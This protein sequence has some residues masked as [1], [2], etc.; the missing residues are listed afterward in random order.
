MPPKLLSS[1]SITVW[2]PDFAPRV[3]RERNVDSSGPIDPMLPRDHTRKVGITLLLLVSWRRC[4]ELAQAIHPRN[5]HSMSLPQ[6]IVVIGQFPGN[7]KTERAHNLWDAR[8]GHHRYSLGGRWSWDHESVL[9]SLEVE[10]Q[11][12]CIYLYEHRRVLGVSYYISKLLQPNVLIHSYNNTL[13]TITYLHAAT[14][15]QLLLTQEYTNL[16]RRHSC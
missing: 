15:Q 14:P 12:E 2:A 6:G 10:R 4:L 5:R 3:S 16:L 9:T 1:S 13:F 7:M 8:G 11:N